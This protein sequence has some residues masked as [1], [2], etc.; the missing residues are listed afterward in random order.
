MSKE[1]ENEEVFETEPEVT[2]PVSDLTVQSEPAVGVNT[3]S[4][5]TALSGVTFSTPGIN[6][7]FPFTEQTFAGTV[8]GGYA[9]PTLS[10]AG[11]GGAFLQGIVTQNGQYNSR[12]EGGGQ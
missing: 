3:P 11:Y 7:F 12:R 5:Y 8:S 1:T 9:A 4:S 10:G 2:A 6:W